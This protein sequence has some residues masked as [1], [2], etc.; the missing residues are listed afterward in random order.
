[1]QRFR[2]EG[3]RRQF[4]AQGGMVL[5]AA[6]GLDH[7]A[8]GINLRFQRLSAI[9]LLARQ[10][11]QPASAMSYSV[12]T[13]FHRQ[14]PYLPR[15]RGGPFSV[16]CGS[17][18]KY[19]GDLADFPAHG[20]SAQMFRV[21]SAKLRRRRRYLEGHPTAKPTPGFNWRDAF[22]FENRWD[23]LPEAITAPAAADR[24]L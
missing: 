22:P 11:Q 9:Q 6:S 1:V 14:V 13:R 15:V 17:G 16:A 8:L 4:M 5:K 7:F 10:R 23:I 20:F 3:A 2:D 19:S 12:R 21:I 24:R 18:T